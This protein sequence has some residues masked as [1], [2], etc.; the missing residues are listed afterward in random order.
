MTEQ[1]VY[2]I[3]AVAQ[4]TGISTHALRQWERRYPNLH[5]VRTASGLRLYSE[6]QVERLRLIHKLLAA[7]HAI[8]TLAPM[9]TQDL[10]GL[11]QT[12]ARPRP[13]EALARSHPDALSAT[14]TRRFLEAM[15]Q[16]DVDAAERL[17]AQAFL[18]FS[19]VDLVGTVLVPLLQEVGARW[20]DG[21]LNISEEHA[22]SAMLRSQ[23]GAALRAFHPP[24]D[25]PLALATTPSG[26]LHELGALLAALV[27]AAAGW[28]VHYLGPNLPAAAIAEAAAAQTC[29]AVLLSVVCLA[30][31]RASEEIRL[32]R[33]LLPAATRLLV[34]GS[35]LALTEWPRGVTLVPSLADV[36]DALAGRTLV[37]AP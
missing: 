37:A 20:A 6:T 12:V 9:A 34:G 18:A 4:L 26:E 7:G 8:G 1:G 23:L 2:R 13:V 21:R 36:V 28:R 35:Q 5:P 17:L 27:A 32:T 33:R 14:F 15:A 29:D 11:D 16:Q 10:L 3:G 19:P 25:A 31:D 30:V 24:A 22:I